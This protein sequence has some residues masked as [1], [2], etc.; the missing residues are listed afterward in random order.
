MIVFVAEVLDP[1]GEVVSSFAKVHAA[2]GVTTVYEWDKATRKPVVALRLE[3]SPKGAGFRQWT[4]EDPAGTYRVRD[5]GNC[6]CGHPLKH[7]SLPR[8]VIA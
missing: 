5:T 1:A 3:G 4:V 8:P 7:A 2:Q 6:G